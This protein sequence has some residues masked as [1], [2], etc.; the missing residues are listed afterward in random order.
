MTNIDFKF[1]T[2][3]RSGPTLKYGGKWNAELIESVRDTRTNADLTIHIKVFFSKID[4]AGATGFRGDADD[5]SEDSTMI[6]PSQKKIQKWKPGEFELYTQKLVSSAQKFWNGKFWLQTPSSYNDLNYPDDRPTHRC[7]LY[8]R[9]KL[10][11]ALTEHDSHYT[12]AVVRVQDDVAFRSHSTLFSQ[13][14]IESEKMIPGST[15]KFW[16]HFHEVGHLIGLA[17]VGTGAQ[18]R[19]NIQGNNSPTAYGVTIQE[20]RD[21]MGRGSI[22]HKWHA[23]PWREA[24]E[25]FT[26]V[27]AELWKVHQHRK[28]PSHL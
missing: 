11:R 14:D 4:P 12:I 7:N 16:T 24:A 5:P 3:I 17:H 26:G 2:L 18:A 15:T 8:C 9:F 13:K 10:D 28:Y 27:K 1:G 25:A 20:M 19:K 21:A 23:T 22:R 6:A